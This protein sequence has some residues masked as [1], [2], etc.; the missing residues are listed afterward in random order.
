MELNWLDIGLFLAFFAVTVGT[1]LYK[2]WREETGEDFFLASRGLY[3]PIIGISLIAAN[4]S[5]EH[6]VVRCTLFSAQVLKKRHLHH[7][8]IP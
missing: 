7:A 5:T 1:S 4:I 2:S 8:G 6:F 3:W